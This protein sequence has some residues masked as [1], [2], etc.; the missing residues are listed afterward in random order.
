ML[1]LSSIS[2]SVDRGWDEFFQWLPKLVGFLII[3]LIGYVVAK[4]VGGIVARTLGRAGF[5]RFLER[6]AGGS[7]AMRVIDSPSK[8]LGTLTFWALFLGALSIAVDVL[9]IAAL[10]DLIHSVWA[11][12]PN[13]L[14]A[15]LI[16]VVAGAIAGGLAALIERTMGDTA[17]GRIVKVVAP[18][19]VMAIATFMILDELQIASNIV[20]ITYA[21]LMGAIALALALA[22]GLGGRD[23][24]ARLLE[25]GY[26]KG[27]AVKDDVARDVRVGVD[28]GRQQAHD[29]GGSS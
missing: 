14:A 1:L 10:E 23:V 20:V 27:Q 21:A 9:G 4:I 22:F 11:Y 8:L 13:I 28:R 6:G 2:D 5:D 25:N 7:Y 17:T 26:A 15:L 18:V 24:A 29:L 12:I 19:L 16:F 3:I